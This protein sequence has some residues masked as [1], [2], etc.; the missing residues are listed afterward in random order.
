MD[1]GFELECKLNFDSLGVVVDNSFV[2][3]KPDNRSVKDDSVVLPTCLSDTWR[4]SSSI[5][6]VHWIKRSHESDSLLSTKAV[7]L[8][9]DNS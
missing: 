7:G 5:T 1:H 9:V 2:D 6:G 3:P 4:F 8:K